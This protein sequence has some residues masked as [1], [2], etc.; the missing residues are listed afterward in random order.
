MESWSRSA[1][2]GENYILVSHDFGGG[3]VFNREY[4]MQPELNPP[5]GDMSA[6][7]KQMT[8]FNQ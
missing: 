8:H 5:P 3:E 6:A 2:V 4:Q 7:F 1:I